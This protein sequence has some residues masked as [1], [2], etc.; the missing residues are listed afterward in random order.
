MNQLNAYFSLKNKV[1]LVTGAARGIALHIACAVNAAGAR[2]AILDV[3][4]QEAMPWPGCSAANR[5]GPGSGS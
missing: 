3:R 1:A 5:A 2:L 4:E